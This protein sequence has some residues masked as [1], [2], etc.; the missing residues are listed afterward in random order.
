MLERLRLEFLGQN[1]QLSRAKELLES[2]DPDFD[3]EVDAVTLE[4]FSNAC[5]A[6]PPRPPTPV[7]IGLRA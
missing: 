6:D 2:L 7:A 4:A 5:D 1:D 3:I